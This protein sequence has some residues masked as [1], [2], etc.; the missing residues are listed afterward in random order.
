MRYSLYST[1]FLVELFPFHARAKGI[2]VFQWW[3]RC[4][5]F[6]NQF[7][8]PIG[9][10]NAGTMRPAF[11][12]NKTHSFRSGW[13]YYISYV[14]FLAFE[15]VFVYFLFPETS[16]RS[17]EDLAFRTLNYI[18]CT[19]L[20]LISEQCTRTTSKPPK[21]SALS[22]SSTRTR[23]P[24]PLDRTAWTRRRTTPITSRTPGSHELRT[25]W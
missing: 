15:V 8:N 23:R 1:A 11:T 17:L 12:M 4:A 22:K 5:G 7:V 20:S 10:K 21:R 2:A 19:I 25:S 13:K 18:M 14:V 24:F 16:G 9:I 3:G 6:F